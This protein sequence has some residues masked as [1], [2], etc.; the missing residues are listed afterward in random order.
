MRAGVLL[1]A[2]LAGCAAPAAPSLRAYVVD[3][4]WVVFIGEA[5][6]FQLDPYQVPD[7]DEPAEAVAACRARQP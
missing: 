3:H 6:C 2:L 1:L 7:L 4:R 5:V